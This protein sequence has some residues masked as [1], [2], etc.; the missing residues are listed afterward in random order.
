MSE[1]TRRES[2]RQLLERS[3]NGVTPDELRMYVSTEHQ[4]SL[5]TRQIIEELDHVHQSLRHKPGEL[6]VR[7]PSCTE[8]GFDEFDKLL[9]VP[10][11]C[12]ACKSEKVEQPAYRIE[13]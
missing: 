12:P 6:L 9:A 11:R 5:D 13:T 8:C 1:R 3:V 7:P 10:S 2:I 4:T